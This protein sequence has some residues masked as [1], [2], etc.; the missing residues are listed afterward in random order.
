MRGVRWNATQTLRHV[1]PSQKGGIIRTD[2]RAD[3]EGT[4]QRRWVSVPAMRPAVIALIF[5]N[6][7][8]LIGVAAYGWSSYDLFALYWVENLVIALFTVLRFWTAAPQGRMPPI[9]AL[10]FLTPFFLVHY[11]L[12][13]Y[14]H[15]VFI[16]AFLGGDE[17]SIPDGPSL[18]L[19]HTLQG[20]GAIAAI[21][22]LGSHGVSFVTNYLLH[23][24]RHANLAA[25]MF[26]PYGRVV[27][28]HL[29]LLVGGALLLLFGSPTV[30]VALLVVAKTVADLAAHALEHRRA[31]AAA[32]P[33]TV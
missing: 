5:A 2:Q 20:S 25:L 14:V 29:T 28:M 22:L 17:G 1:H 27:A 8:P 31:R 15:G 32:A 16:H 3:L 23:E 10:L 12:F 9:A 26:A 13:T 4:R 33:D 19:E 7:V 21:A 18:L 11:G 30:L 24:R 6:L